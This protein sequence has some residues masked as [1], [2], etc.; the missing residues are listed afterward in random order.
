MPAVE[1]AKLDVVS[2]SNVLQCCYQT[3]KVADD[4][5]SCSCTLTVQPGYQSNTLRPNSILPDRNYNNA[6]LIKPELVDN[7]STKDLSYKNQ[8][9]KVKEF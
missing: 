8:N 6:F 3:G 1:T 4:T 9:C 2:A 7:D 5:A